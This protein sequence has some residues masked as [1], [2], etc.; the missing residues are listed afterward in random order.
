LIC[1]ACVGFWLCVR[2]DWDDEVRKAAE[3]LREEGDGE[4]RKDV[5]IERAV[6]STALDNE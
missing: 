5:D 2:T 6:E 1:T 4:G 3:R